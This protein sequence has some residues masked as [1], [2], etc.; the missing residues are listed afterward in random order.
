MAAIIIGAVV[1]TYIGGTL[2]NDGQYNPIKW[3]YSSGRTWGY[4]AGGAIVG[5]LA[6]WAGGAIAASGIPMANTAG[7]AT[8]S[9]INS[10]GTW[11]YTG[12]QTPITMSLGVAS[13]DFTNGTFGYLGKKGNSTLENIGYTFGA[14]ANVA[15]VVSL[16]GGGTNVNAI[17]EKKD[18]ISHAAVTGDGINI[19]VGP[20]GGGYF[21][22]NQSLGG[23]IKNLFKKVPGDGDWANHLND[24]HGWKLPVNNVNKNILG[25]LSDNLALG[26]NFVGNPL[27][28]SGV[29]Y[30]C[31]SY[32][33]RALWAAGVP[34]IGLHPYLWQASLFVRQ[35][36]IYSN[37]YLYQIPRY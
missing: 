8:S 26:K 21:D 32:A 36:G 18:G 12:G 27:Q 11:A 24:G 13:I 14:L 7:I 5:G 3:D 31:V 17:T 10:V 16:F 28:Y 30:S 35:V 25:K 23:Q 29:G 22:K 37:P 4:M 9:L 20:E 15:D 6:G 1:G 2:A 19:S 33:S 34:N